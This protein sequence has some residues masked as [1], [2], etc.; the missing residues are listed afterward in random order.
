MGNELLILS[1]N[2]R[3]NRSKYNLFTNRCN[4]TEAHL[5]HRIEWCENVLAGGRHLIIWWLPYKLS[6]GHHINYL[7]PPWLSTICTATELSDSHQKI[8]IYVAA[9]RQFMWRV[10]A[11]IFS[12]HSIC[13]M[14][15]LPYNFKV[16]IVDDLCIVF[17][18]RFLG[19]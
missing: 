7:L 14:N 19:E 13:G 11:K 3:V 1:S 2:R 6:G 8:Y 9:A 16:Q 5:C 10:P 4:S 17:C 18:V 15:R 12:L